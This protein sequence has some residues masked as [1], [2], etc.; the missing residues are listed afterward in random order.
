MASAHPLAVGMVVMLLVAALVGGIVGGLVAA[1][2]A[3]GGP[4]A[5]SPPQQIMLS[6]LQPGMLAVTWV[7]PYGATYTVITPPSA[8]SYPMWTAAAAVTGGAPAVLPRVEWQLLGVG[9]PL[10]APANVTKYDYTLGT[11]WRL[12]VSNATSPTIFSALIGP[13]PPGAAFTYRVGDDANGFSPRLQAAAPRAAGTAGVSLA[14]IGDL[15]TT[16]NSSWTRDHVLAAHATVPF[17]AVIH[18]GD[19][20][21]ADGEQ[22]IWDLFGQLVQP[23]ASVLPFNSI[24]GKCVRRGGGGARGTRR[25]AFATHAAAPVSPPP[26]S[27][28]TNGDPGPACRPIRPS[29]H[30]PF[31]SCPTSRGTARPPAAT[32]R[33]STIRSTT[34]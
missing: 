11:D 19:L 4:A 33:A 32:R 21:Y 25:M 20:S 28:A 7:I 24:V 16:S 13:L 2:A 30:P 29:T 22:P 31:R 6:A 17:D 18:L 12:T 23:L 5:G 10:S 9:G 14:V 26:P 8:A 34:A 1:A 3:R 27:A 15:G